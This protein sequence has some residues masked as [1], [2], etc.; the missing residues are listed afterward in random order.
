MADIKKIGSPPTPRGWVQTEREAHEAW[1]KLIARRPRAAEV[2]HY[3]VA[4]MGPR[5][6]VVISQKTL[7]KMTG[8]SVETIKRAIRDLVAERW[9]ET[10]KLNGPGTVNAYVVNSRVAWAESREKLRLAVF[11]AAIVADWADQE[12]PLLGSGDLRRI[13]VLYPGEQQLP[14]GD[15]EPPPSQTCLD[16]MEPDLPALRKE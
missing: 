9:I 7:A 15:G 16:G 11:S 5:N 1:A 8:R 10:V 4:H 14:A 2:L 6:A 13:P 3:L 12:A